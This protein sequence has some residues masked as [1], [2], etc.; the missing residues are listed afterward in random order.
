[1]S[2]LRHDFLCLLDGRGERL[3]RFYWIDVELLPLAF[4]LGKL[5]PGISSAWAWL[6][7]AQNQRRVVSIDLTKKIGRLSTKAVAQINLG[8]KSPDQISILPRR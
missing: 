8:K 1:M 5:D 2:F 4:H 6:N 3:G 7:V